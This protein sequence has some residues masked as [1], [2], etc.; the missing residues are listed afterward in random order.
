MAAC[1]VPA[2]TTEPKKE[3]HETHC[4]ARCRD[5]FLWRSSPRCPRRCGSFRQRRQLGPDGKH[6]SPAHARWQHAQ[7]VWHAR[8]GR[9]WKSDGRDGWNGRRWLWESNGRNGRIWE[10]D[11]RDEWHG[12]IWESNGRDGRNGRWRIWKSDERHGRVWKWNGI[13]RRDAC[14]RFTV[15]SLQSN[16]LQINFISAMPAQALRRPAQGLFV[17]A[18]LFMFERR[19]DC[20]VRAATNCAV[21]LE[22]DECVDAKFSERCCKKW[23]AA[24]DVSAVTTEPKG[25]GET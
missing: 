1:D 3:T 12:R 25:K 17:F 11:G 5:S 18:H 19:E 7:P 4:H 13:G 10:S 2:V 23:M 14:P 8:H 16:S 15:G 9:M 24:C 22:A 21:Q 6:G 20:S